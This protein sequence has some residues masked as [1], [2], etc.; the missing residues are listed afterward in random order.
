MKSFCIYCG[1]SKP[2]AHQICG[3]CAATPETHDDLIYS[4]IMSY[5]ADEPYL[6]FLSIEEIE[7]LCEDIGKGEEIKVNPEVFTQA[8]EAYS[9]VRSMESSPLLSKFSRNASPLHMVIL[10]LVLLGLIFGA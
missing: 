7:A 10:V 3:S 5:S 9:A 2:E 8:K 6:N 4:I 1:N